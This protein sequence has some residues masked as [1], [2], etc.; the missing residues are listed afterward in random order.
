[1]TELPDIR[2]RLVQM[3]GNKAPAQ[4]RTA[5]EFDALP[6]TAKEQIR[7]AS[8]EF[9]QALKG[10]PGLLPAAVSL[11][12]DQGAL[13]PDDIEAL[14]AAG[15]DADATKVTGKM[16]NEAMEA[17]EEGHVRRMHEHQARL[18]RQREAVEATRRESYIQAQRSITPQFR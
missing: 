10:D 1:M 16:L 14:R 12:R 9:Y 2:E 18:A 8:P 7:E 5:E 4:P 3:F 15:L 11:R 13:G 17:L 6:L